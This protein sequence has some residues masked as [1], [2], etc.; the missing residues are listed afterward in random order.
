MSL[1]AD[2]DIVAE[3][4]KLSPSLQKIVLDIIK[5]YC[6]SDYQK[7]RANKNKDRVKE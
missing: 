5:S 7:I 4:D 2:K 6:L 1:L 3:I